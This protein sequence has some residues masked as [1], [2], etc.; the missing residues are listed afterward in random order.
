MRSS[1]KSVSNGNNNSDNMNNNTIDVDEDDKRTDDDIIDITSTECEGKLLNQAGNCESEL[2]QRAEHA[3]S[4]QSTA[5]VNVY[6]QVRWIDEM[7]REIL[8]IH[9]NFFQRRLLDERKPSRW[10]VKLE[11][12]AS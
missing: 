8:F 1:M 11:F 12:N 10:N 6:E 4:E 7:F 5:K 9:W 2:T 3:D